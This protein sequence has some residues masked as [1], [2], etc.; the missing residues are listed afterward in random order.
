MP[1]YFLFCLVGAPLGGDSNLWFFFLGFLLEPN[2]RPLAGQTLIQNF[3]QLFRYQ[4]T[5]IKQVSPK[6]KN[7]Q[8]KNQRFQ[9]WRLYP[10]FATSSMHVKVNRSFITADQFAYPLKRCLQ[11]TCISLSRRMADAAVA[12]K[13]FTQTLVRL[14]FDCRKEVNEGV[15]K[16]LVRFFLRCKERSSVSQLD[17]HISKAT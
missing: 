7:L 11:L 16:N 4:S 9:F 14:V 1:T 10:N 8:M 13:R 3:N 2:Q 17:L 6:T 12:W 15:S 5:C